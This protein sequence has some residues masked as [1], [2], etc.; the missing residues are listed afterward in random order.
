[1]FGFY[2]K[3]FLVYCKPFFAVF[4]KFFQREQRRIKDF[5]EKLPDAP[6]QS[7]AEGAEGAPEQRKPPER[8]DQEQRRHVE[9]ERPAPRTHAEQK[10]SSGEHR[11]EHGVREDAD[12]PSAALAQDAQRVIDAA[13]CQACQKRG[14]NREQLRAQGRGKAV[15]RNSRDHSPPLRPVSS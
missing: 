4:P 14:E 9:P 7:P 13:Q 2:C 1:M 15:H 12:H 11:D 3:P 6:V 5:A 10:Q 8:P